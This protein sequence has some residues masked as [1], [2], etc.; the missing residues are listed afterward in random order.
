MTTNWRKKRKT[1]RHGH[2]TEA[3][4]K[5]AVAR[6]SA[7]GVESLSLRELAKDAGVNSTGRPVIFRSCGVLLPGARV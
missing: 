5:A 1:F 7:D 2:L 3:L 6:L 4:V